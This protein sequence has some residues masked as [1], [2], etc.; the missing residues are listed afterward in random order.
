[1]KT[2]TLDEIKNLPPITEKRLQEIED[3]KTTDFS[4]CPELT[5]LQLKKLQPA[6]SA[7]SEW[8]SG[9]KETIQVNIDTDIIEALKAQGKEYQTFINAILR[10][11]IL[12]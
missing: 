7:K 3:F 10:K 1:M 6:Y 4:D 9:K 8:F 2:M 12:G 5:D 11:A